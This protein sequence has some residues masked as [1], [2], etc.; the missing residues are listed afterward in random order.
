MV[1]WNK[2]CTFLCNS[3]CSQAMENSKVF[4][5]MQETPLDNQEGFHS[6]APGRTRTGDLRITNALLYQLS[7]GSTFK[8]CCCIT[9]Q[10]VTCPGIEPGFT[11]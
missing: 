7:H 9:K 8:K 6:S 2:D 4:P 11:P 3:N 5:I 1:I 10:Q